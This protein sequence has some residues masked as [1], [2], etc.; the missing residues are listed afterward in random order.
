MVTHLSTV[1]QRPQYVK[2]SGSF[3]PGSPGGPGVMRGP[4]LGVMPSYAD[5]QEGLLLDGVTDNTPAAKAGLKAGDR[6]VEIA[7]KPVKNITAYMT[8]MG[9]FKRGD[10][11]ELSAVRDGKVQK[12]QVVLE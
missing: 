12:F 1:E 4:R 11:F 7:G 3:N 10:K 2:V 8:I 5:E 9:G 6:I